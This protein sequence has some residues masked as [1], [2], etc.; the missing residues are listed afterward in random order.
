MENLYKLQLEVNLE[1]FD[2]Y[3]DI[4]LNSSIC[5]ENRNRV[6]FRFMARSFKTV[7]L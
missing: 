2:L 6:E 4:V 5:K 1:V 3:W 7:I